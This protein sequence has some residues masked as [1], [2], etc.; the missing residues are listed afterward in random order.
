MIFAW[1]PGPQFSRY[2][3]YFLHSEFEVK[4]EDQTFAYWYSNYWF[5]DS[6]AAFKRSQRNWGFRIKDNIDVIHTESVY[7]LRKQKRLFDGIGTLKS[8]NGFGFSQ[9]VYLDYHISLR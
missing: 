8:K 5:L 3:W 4:S 7:I 1:Q 6:I 2:N 9:I